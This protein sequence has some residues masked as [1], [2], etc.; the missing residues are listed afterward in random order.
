SNQS[1][2]ALAMG[3]GPLPPSLVVGSGIVVLLAGWS[4]VG[5]AEDAISG[6]YVTAGTRAF[7]TVLLLE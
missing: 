5:S 7:E 6:F 1:S 3:S 4:L 2:I